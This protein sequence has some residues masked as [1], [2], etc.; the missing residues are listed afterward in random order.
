MARAGAKAP[1]SNKVKKATVPKPR[2]TAAPKKPRVPKAR[3]ATGE[4]SSL[5]SRKRRG[6]RIT[7][8]L[9][10]MDDENDDLRQFAGVFA[11]GSHSASTWGTLSSGP[12]VGTVGSVRKSIFRG[13]KSSK[14][15]HTVTCFS[16]LIA[17][18]QEPEIESASREPNSPTRSLFLRYPLEVREKIYAILLRSS[19]SILL[20]YD[21]EKVERSPS[22]Y[23]GILRVCRQITAEATPFLY[24][25]NIFHAVLRRS[26]RY[27]M[28]SFDPLLISP[29]SLHLFKNVLLECPATNFHSAWYGEVARSLESLGMAKPMLESLTI[30]VSP[31]RVG[32]TSTALGL[33]ANPITFADFFWLDG[34]IM[35]AIMELRCKTL[36]VVVKKGNRRRVL[37]EVDLRYVMLSR[38]IETQNDDPSWFARD[39]SCLEPRLAREAKAIEELAVLKERFEGIFKNDENAVGGG[40]CRFMDA[41]EKI[42]EK[43][44]CWES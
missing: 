42:I 9:L 39:P 33:E 6:H 31:Q 3:N 10:A 32:M 22:L 11:P 40:W 19:S 21:W 30:V 1:T 34:G 23:L 16:E 28:F 2:K 13:Q 14:Q 44:L 29:Q 38:K 27:N 26:S 5:A 41:D 36:R 25:I 18:W 24:R 37:M 43:G 17:D 12:I 35:K 20:G 4:P 7:R 15:K 8:A